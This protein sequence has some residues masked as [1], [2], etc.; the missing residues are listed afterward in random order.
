MSRCL[1]GVVVGFALGALRFNLRS[2]FGVWHVSLSV[3]PLTLKII[4]PIFR[5]GSPFLL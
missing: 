4:D 5:K 2:V 1:H 3:A